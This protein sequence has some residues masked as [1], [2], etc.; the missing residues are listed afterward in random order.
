MM[1]QRSLIE[2][3]RDPDVAGRFIAAVASVLERDAH[4]LEVS[5]NER[6]I[7]HRLGLYMAELFPEWDVDCEYNRDGERPKEIRIGSGDDGENGSRVL[8][9]VIVHRRDS[10][11]NHVVVEVK[12]DSNPEGNVRDVEKLRDYCDVLKYRH[13]VFVCFSVGRNRAGVARAHFVYGAT[14]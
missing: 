9:D 13:G 12:K 2:S 8:P 10:S 6:A 11:N 4:L 5:C 1:W 14:M 7:S 3:C